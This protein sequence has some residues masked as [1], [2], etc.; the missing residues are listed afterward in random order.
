MEKKRAL[1]YSNSSAS[2]GRWRGRS[3]EDHV[4]GVD[5]SFIYT[6]SLKKNAENDMASVIQHY[7]SVTM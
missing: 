3:K 7:K 1:N 4:D 6:L 2:V 5:L